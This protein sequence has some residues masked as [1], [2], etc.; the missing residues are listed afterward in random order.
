MVREMFSAKKSMH[1]NQ[2][3]HRYS[4]QKC[5]APA[6]SIIRTGAMSLDIYKWCEIYHEENCC[7]AVSRAHHAYVICVVTVE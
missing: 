3:P 4:V 7:T 2:A 5:G 6:Q 1:W